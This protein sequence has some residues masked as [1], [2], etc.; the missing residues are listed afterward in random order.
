MSDGRINQI[1]GFFGIVLVCAF[2]LGLAISIGEFPF[3]VIA[4]FVLS[5]AAIEFW[6]S[7]RDTLAKERE[8]KSD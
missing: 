5:L 3:I 8:A 4:I 6:Q 2:V 7:S 1:C